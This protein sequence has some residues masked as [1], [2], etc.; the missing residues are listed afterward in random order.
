MDYQPAML[1]EL[2]AAGEV[3]WAGPGSL[4]GT[5]G[6]VSLHLAE[7]AALTLPDLDPG[8]LSG[9]DAT[10]G[11]LHRQVLDAL[12]GGGAYFFRQLSDA[13]GA[14]DDQALHAALWDLVWSG[15]VGN[16]TLAPVR[17]LVTA[18]ARPT[19]PV[20]PPREP[21]CTAAAQAAR[22]ARDAVSH[23]ATHG[24]R[25]LVAAA[26]ARRR[27]DPACPRDRRAD[28]RPARR[29]DPRGGDQRAGARRLRGR[30]QGARRR[31][32]SP[33]AAVV[34]TSSRLSAPPSSRR[35]ARS[36]GCAPSPTRRTATT[37]AAAGG[38]D[39]RRAVTLAATDPA[40]PYGAALG[41][42]ARSG[43]GDDRRRL[44]GHRPGRKAGALVVLVD[45]ELV[46]YVERGGRTLLT[47]TGPGTG[48][49]TGPGTGAGNGPDVGGDVDDDRLMIAVDALALAVRDGSLGRI[50]V[51]RADG[52]QVLGSRLGAALE[53]AGFHA[54][55]RGLR[56]RA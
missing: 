17:T 46:L 48:S 52:E 27:R 9:P 53:A 14:T 41:W 2:T 56:L 19:A 43:S 39:G 54:T 1:D 11:D 20:G 22:P 51:Q 8:E 33:A 42:P 31:S 3:L 35:P 36:T 6:W 37:G 25:T 40:N 23:R 26:G 45:G 29:R 18:A 16:D 47:F 32:R 5:D 30:L 10:F 55:P 21:G 24:R 44:A 34:A 12:A 4:P 15:R 38:S 7:S 49:G 13:V 50:T 28:A